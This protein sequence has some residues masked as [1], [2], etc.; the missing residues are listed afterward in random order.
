MCPPT[1]DRIPVEA[2]PLPIYESIPL[3]ENIEWLVQ[4]LRQHLLGGGFRYES[5][6]SNNHGYQ[7]CHMSNI[8]THPTQTGLWILYRWY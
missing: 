4:L 6:A 3:M 1:G 7:Q 5:G 2:D 8:R